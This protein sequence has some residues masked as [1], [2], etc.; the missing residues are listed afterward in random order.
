MLSDRYIRVDKG[1]SLVYLCD[2]IYYIGFFGNNSCG[3]LSVSINKVSGN[4]F[5][6]V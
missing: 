5:C 6:G 1:K 4:I 2:I 3:G